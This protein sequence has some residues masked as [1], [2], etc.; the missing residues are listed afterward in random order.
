M[1]SL[2]ASEVSSAPP[3]KDQI[4]F[5]RPSIQVEIEN[6]DLKLVKS[7]YIRGWMIDLRYIFIFQKCLPAMS[8]LHTINLWNVGLNDTTF[9][10]FVSVLR[11]CAN[12]KTVVLD[13]N[14]IP[15]HPYHQ[16][17]SEDS[18]FQ[19]LTL[20]NNL[21]DDEGAK[22]IGEALSTIKRANKMVLSI[23]LSF[24]H[25]TDIGAIHIAN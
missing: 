2:P 8:N 12:L 20:R 15:G 7:V 24:N 23:N 5:F 22:L 19:H 16:L 9:S 1:E 11:Q 18:P 14:P 17:L 13:G 10:A 6:D 21:I 3:T 4:S 25:I